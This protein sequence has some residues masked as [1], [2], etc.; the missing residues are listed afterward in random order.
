MPIVQ[1]ALAIATFCVVLLFTLSCGGSAISKEARKKAQE[2]WDA[3]VVKCGDDLYTKVARDGINMGRAFENKDQPL[4]QFKPV[5]VQIIEDPI[6]D[7]DKLNGIEWKG[8][9]AIPLKLTFRYYDEREK[10]WSSWREGSVIYAP[11]QLRDA[12][13]TL[14]GKKVDYPLSIE[15][16][17]EKGQWNYESNNGESKINPLAKPDCADIPKD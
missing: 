5:T 10:K 17:K 9:A 4:I 1:R 8:Y 16:R 2:W 13:N 3:S 12:F 14:A 6:T 7:A 15:L 11:N